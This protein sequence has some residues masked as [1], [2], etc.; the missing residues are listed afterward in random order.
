MGLVLLLPNVRA[1]ARTLSN[2]PLAV[3]TGTA[4]NGLN[5]KVLT[6]AVH[7]TDVY[8]GGEFTGTTDETLSGLN[9]IA[10]WD[11]AAWHPLGLGLN[12]TVFALAFDSQNRLYVGGRFDATC[13]Q[14]SCGGSD[15]KVAQVAMWDGAQWS[16]VGH[17]L[18]G[19]VETL[20]VDAN[21]NLY[22]GG[23]FVE[24]CGS[25]T[26]T[27]NT[28]A[29]RVAKWNGTT[30][31]SLAFGLNASVNALAVAG[32]GTLYAGGNFFEYCADAACIDDTGTDA[33]SIAKF[34]NGAWSALP[35]GGLDGDVKTLAFMSN[36][37]YVAEVL[38]TR[39][40]AA[41]LQCAALPNSAATRGRLSPTTDSTT[42]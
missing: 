24:I 22:A 40:K 18:A 5:G 35:L 1:Q 29:N 12:D 34:S 9:R 26:C 20:T 4:N 11:G 38:Q 19:E 37:L 17:G 32:D 33:A 41:A 6:I 27:S 25:S 31:K 21:D 15:V 2:A 10:R 36:T 13:L 39:S 8:V 7:G 23:S 14:A 28:V 3:W 42:P 16:G 30:W